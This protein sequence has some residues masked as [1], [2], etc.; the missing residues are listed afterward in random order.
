LNIFRILTGL[1]SGL[2]LLQAHV[3]LA[4]IEPL[5][6]NSPEQESQ[7]RRLLA[8]VRCLVC[9]NQSL[10]ESNAGLATD[11]RKIIYEQIQKNARDEEIVDFLVSRYGDFVL[12]RPP[13]K[14]TT[15]LLWYGP[16]ALMLVGGTVV[17]LLIRKR[18]T[19][20]QTELSVEEQK[21]IKDLLDQASGANSSGDEQS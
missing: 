14:K 2:M 19:I 18:R 17:V 5:T 8:E 20:E 12:Y 11:L 1:I 16:L 9:Q 7:Y 4:A 15:Y 10:A 21:E 6:F 3:S 13:V